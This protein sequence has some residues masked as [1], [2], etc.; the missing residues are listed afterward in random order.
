[1]SVGFCCKPNPGG[2]L[3]S[4]PVLQSQY[5]WQS[6][7]FQPASHKL[8]WESM[9]ECFFK[10]GLH[11]MHTKTVA[12]M[13]KQVWHCFLVCHMQLQQLQLSEMPW[14]CMLGPGKLNKAVKPDV[15]SS[16]VATKVQHCDSHLCL[17]AA[18]VQAALHNYA[19][20]SIGIYISG[21]FLQWCTCPLVFNSL[22]M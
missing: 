21:M 7:S 2:W 10:V 22:Y 11:H 4:S 3:P 8:V 9:L 1:M 14:N 20:V 6:G 5:L 15:A 12:A 19:L 18:T 16:H 13:C 17:Q